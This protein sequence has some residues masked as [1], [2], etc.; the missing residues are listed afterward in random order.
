YRA[1]AEEIAAGATGMR[2]DVPA[3]PVD[4]LT[5][6]GTTLNTMVDALERSGER[7]RQFIDDAS[8][9]LRTPLSVLSAEIDVALRKPRTT[10]EYEA[11]LLRLKADTNNLLSLAE[12]LLTLGALGSTTPNAIDVSATQLLADAAL[13]ARGKLGT[14]HRRVDVEVAD[15]VIVHG[16]QQLL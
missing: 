8:H 15:E 1:R 7:Q 3:G 11:T 5:R 10:T 12:T 2:L 6:L 4:E 13:R 16:E 9:E 14:P